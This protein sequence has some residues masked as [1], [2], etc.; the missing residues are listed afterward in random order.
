MSFRK[1]K[2]QVL[3]A[4]QDAVAK[5]NYPEVE[6]KIE[7]PP[8]SELG[9]IST[10]VCFQISRRIKKDVKEVSEDL[11]NEIDIRE[12]GLISSVSTHQNGYINFRANYPE[13]GFISLKSAILDS[14]YGHVD[15]GRGENVMVEHTSVNP[16]KA[17]HVGHLRNVILG[18]AITRILKFTNHNVTV[19]NYI[20]DSGTQVAELILGFKILEFP[21]C[22]GK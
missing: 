13:M 17:L 5:R 6:F 9:D 19:M 21:L 7:E 4:L 14:N 11:V 2:G 20:D 3:S 10:N 8:R 22:A 12:R 15:I 1:F 16:N 18:D